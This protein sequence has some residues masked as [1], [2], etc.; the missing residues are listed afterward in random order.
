MSEP[1]PGFSI[2]QRWK[3]VVVYW[4]G[5]RGYLFDAGWG[6]DPRVLYVPS[7]EAWPDAV[8]DWMRERRDE[9]LERLRRHSGHVLDETPVGYDARSAV[10]RSTSRDP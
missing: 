4:E 3:E 7:A 8:P 1:G 6:V 10:A 2:E 5:E 9:V